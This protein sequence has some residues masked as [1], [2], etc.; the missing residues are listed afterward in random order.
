MAVCCTPTSRVAQ[1]S[2]VRAP[3]GVGTWAWLVKH[4]GVIS[5]ACVGVDS[6]A[7]EDEDF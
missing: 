1:G 5:E 2:R 6:K 7:R 4:R 3:G